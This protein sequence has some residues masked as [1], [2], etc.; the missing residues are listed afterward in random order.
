MKA[1]KHLHKGISL[2]EVIVVFAVTSVFVAYTLPDLGGLLI[3][4]KVA[5]GLSLVEPAKAALEQTCESDH[6]AVVKDNLEAG[7]FYIPS[8]T[9]EDYLDRVQLGA[10]CAKKTMVI[11]VWTGST[12]ANTDPVIELTANAPGA[13]EPW[14]CRLI[15]GNASHVPADCRDTYKTT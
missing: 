4:A 5:E 12:G 3:R 11:V 13:I 14:T 7:Y 9:E 10:D 6:Q 15:R 1:R 8:G 2:I